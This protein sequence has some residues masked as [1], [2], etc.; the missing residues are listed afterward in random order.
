[1]E[2]R[3]CLPIEHVSYH[4]I[5]IEATASTGQRVDGKHGVT[6]TIVRRR[7]AGTVNM[8]RH[9]P[10]ADTAT[11]PASPSVSKVPEATRW[12]RVHVLD[13]ANS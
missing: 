7:R 6:S 8:I 11:R 2:N 3:L 5:D 10:A 12:I 1:M 9:K 4:E 13:T